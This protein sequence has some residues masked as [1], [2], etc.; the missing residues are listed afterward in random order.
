MQ[1]DVLIIGQGICG[2]MLSW[3]LHKE[4]KRFVVVDNAN[5]IA[6][7]KVAAGIINPVTG[8][9]YVT[10]WM[11]EEVMPFAKAVYEEA[12]TQLNTELIQP[13]SVIDFFPTP[14]MLHAFVERV[15]E[16]DTYLHSFPDQNHF[17]QHFNYDFGCGEIKPAYIIHISSLLASW[18]KMLSDKSLLLAEEFRLQ[19]LEVGI[20]S[21]RFG[22]VKAD[23]IIFCDGADGFA[24]PWFSLLPFAPN[25]GE[26]LII[27]C[28]GL[29][30]EHIFKRGLTLA[31][32]PEPH[33]FWVGSNYQ[34][35]F[36]DDKP[37]QDF[38]KSTTQH[39]SN[40]LKKP[41]EV[42]GHKAS[43]RPATL[44]R[45]P[46]VGFHPQFPNIGILNGMGTKGAS[47]APYFANQL[48][49]YIVHGLPIAD[50]ADVQRFRGILSR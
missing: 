39:L 8:R 33:T 38:Y 46:F 30:N 45:R 43:I 27:K 15:K 3:F 35:E 1:V 48:S 9:R 14:Q 6:A 40:W 32:L 10:T 24:N 22:D 37:S 23:K 20:D 7:S 47:L 36:S 17:N 11:I 50:D 42:L 4:G 34:W 2:T 49:Q 28:E 26:A 41:Y 29:S 16:D 13:K 44:E 12:S 31:P 21:I 5:P 18:R 19:D 25:K